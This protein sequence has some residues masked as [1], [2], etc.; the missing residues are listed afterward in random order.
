MNPC[1]LCPFLSKSLMPLTK[2][3]FVVLRDVFQLE[4]S[5]EKLHLIF[6][7]FDSN[8]INLFK[9]VIHSTKLKN[10]HWIL[11]QRQWRRKCEIEPNF[12]GCKYQLNRKSRHPF[13]LSCY[14]RI[15]RKN[16]ESN[17]IEKCVRSTQ[18]PTYSSFDAR[19]W[20]HTVNAVRY[21]FG[22]LFVILNNWERI[23]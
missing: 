23:Q 20:Q 19:R 16:I 15:T 17:Q 8:L 11:L 6:N 22:R 4:M 10:S 1:I 12:L 5:A 18:H 9:K 2:P 14:G 21:A 13:M 7:F 3:F